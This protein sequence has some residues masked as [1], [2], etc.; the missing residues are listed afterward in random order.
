MGDETPRKAMIHII[1]RQ[2]AAQ[3]QPLLRGMFADRKRLF[4]D[5]F[6][7]DVPVVDGQYEMDQFDTDDAVY[8]VA[9]YDGEHDASLRLAPTTVPHMLGSVFPHL[10]PHGVPSG[11]TTWESSRLCLPQRHGAERRQVLRNRLISAMVDVA[12]ARGI[13]HYTGILPAP[14]RK[15][16]LAMGWR[17]EPLGPAVPMPGGSVGAFIV[18]I[19]PDTPHRLRWTG[20][21]VGDAE[22]V[23]A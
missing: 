9:G 22:P 16:V 12:L 18:H 11:P 5:L 20:T 19:D 15:E 6:G 17:A 1:D 3:F 7:W 21:Y 14:F 23:L 13:E 8:L 2:N 10:S 4:V